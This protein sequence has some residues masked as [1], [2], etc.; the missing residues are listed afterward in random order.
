[1]SG[2]H[3]DLAQGELVIDGVS[4]HTPAWLVLDLA[5]LWG[6]PA[7]R[8]QNLI[9]PGQ[10]GTRPYARVID[11][12]VCALGFHIVGDVGHTGS[13][14]A[15]PVA[16][17]VANLDYLWANVIS[18]PA[19][20]DGTRFAELTMPDS[21]TRVADIQVRLELE[22]LGASDVKGVLFVTVP[23]GRFEEAGS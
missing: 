2:L 22:P 16:G 21:S 18:V 9:I 4:M 11:E 8:G 23:A 7:E 13:T 6:F 15:D 12:T 17:L 19:T 3:V 20:V 1:M 5:P 10:A 14:N